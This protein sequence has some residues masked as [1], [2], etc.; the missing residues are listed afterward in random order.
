MPSTPFHSNNYRPLEDSLLCWFLLAVS[1]K[2]FSRAWS[3]TG[4]RGDSLLKHPADRSISKEL[5]TS[6]QQRNDLISYKIY[7]VNRAITFRLSSVRR[8]YQSTTTDN[9]RFSSAAASSGIFGITVFALKYLFVF[10][11]IGG[12]AKWFVRWLDCC[13]WS[14]QGLKSSPYWGWFKSFSICNGIGE[15]TKNYESL[16]GLWVN[17]KVLLVSYSWDLKGI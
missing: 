5:T 11:Q 9:R 7:T 6:F 1:L 2:L 17:R 8:I 3:D 12:F 10:L 14:Y 13:W 16:D 4:L 15:F